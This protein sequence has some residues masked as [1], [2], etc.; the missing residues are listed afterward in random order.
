MLMVME[1]DLIGIGG[2][3]IMYVFSKEE[4]VIFLLVELAFGGR[5]GPST[6]VIYG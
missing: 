6:T 3:M 1:M 4:A 5:V 2:R